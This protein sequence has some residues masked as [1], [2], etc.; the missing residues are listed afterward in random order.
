MLGWPQGVYFDGLVQDWSNYS[1][2]AKLII[3]KIE[4]RQA[5]DTEIYM[6]KGIYSDKNKCDFIQ[7][8]AG[9]HLSEIYSSFIEFFWSVSW[10]TSYPDWQTFPKSKDKK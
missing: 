3:W 10:K 8:L 2:L 5:K 1:A 6:E 7:A 9:V 4:N